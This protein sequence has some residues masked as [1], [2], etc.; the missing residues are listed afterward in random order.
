MTRD[1]FARDLAER[2]PQYPN[3]TFTST[4]AIWVSMTSTAYALNRQYA[5]NK[6][7]RLITG[8]CGMLCILVFAW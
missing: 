3:H 4:K 2:F 1:V 7:V 5:L 6:D 8:L